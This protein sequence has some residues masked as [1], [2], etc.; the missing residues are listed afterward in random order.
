MDFK[1]TSEASKNGPV[2]IFT[3]EMVEYG[4]TFSVEGEFLINKAR[5]N[6]NCEEVAEKAKQEVKKDEDDRDDGE[7]IREYA[8]LLGIKNY[9]NKKIDKLVEEIKDVE[10]A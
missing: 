5:L 4:D 3:G 6:D 7:E 8:K 2:M 9:W 10:Q 1:H